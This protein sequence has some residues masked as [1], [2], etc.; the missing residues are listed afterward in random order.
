MCEGRRSEQ[1]KKKQKRSKTSVIVIEK[2][3]KDFG[4]KKT[5][6]RRNIKTHKIKCEVVRDSDKK[7]LL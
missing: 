7:N 5:K 1:K 2:R 4:Q 6:E 3:K